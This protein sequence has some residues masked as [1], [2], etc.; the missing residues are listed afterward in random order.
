M[1]AFVK[2][3]HQLYHIDKKCTVTEIY[4]S[5]YIDG[6]GY[7]DKIDTFTTKTNCV[8]DYG[9]GSVR[10]ERFLDTMVV[11]TIE[12]IRKMVLIAL[13]SA[14]CENR[15][16]HSLIRIMNSIKILDPTF[17]PPI[18]NKTC[19]WQKK[20]V[21]EICKDILPSIIETST[22]KA[23]HVRLFRT[24]QLIESDTLN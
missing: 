2:Q 11:K 21:K 9:K 18:I 14:L 10:Y 20:L 15:N 13:D 19:S 22:N 12:T 4:Y 3:C 5:K 7:E 24:L 8:F 17:V 23:S 1:T 16:I 6:I